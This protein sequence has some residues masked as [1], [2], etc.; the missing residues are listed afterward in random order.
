MCIAY[1]QTPDPTQNWFLYQFN[2][3]RSHDYMKYGIWP[4]ALYMS[5]ATRVARVGALRLRPCTRAL[6]LAGDV[7]VVQRCRRRRRGRT[8]LTAHRPRRLGRREPAT[9]RERQTRSR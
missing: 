8:V 1:S 3:P 4:D 2:L 6:R 7:P 5:D 9:G